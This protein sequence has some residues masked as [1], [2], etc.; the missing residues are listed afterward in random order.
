MDPF[1]VKRQPHPMGGAAS[2]LES[3]HRQYNKLPDRVHASASFERANEHR[4]LDIKKR[5]SMIDEYSEIKKNLEVMKKAYR[6]LH[7]ENAELRHAMMKL[8]SEATANVSGSS[9]PSRDSS[10]HVRDKPESD[11]GGSSVD[12]LSGEVLRPVLPDPRGPGDLDGG[13]G[14]P[15]ALA[16]EG[17]EVGGDGSVDERMRGDGDGEGGG[18]DGPPEA[19]QLDKDGPV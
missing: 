3:I 6:I 16:S 13:K 8:S 4:K 10:V 19:V 2:Y 15:D 7:T 1:F 11:K 17:G 18:A 9:A 14:R 5:E 12:G